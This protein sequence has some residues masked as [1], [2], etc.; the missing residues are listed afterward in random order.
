MGLDPN[1]RPILMEAVALTLPLRQDCSRARPQLL[2]DKLQC[3]PHT[4]AGSDSTGFAKIDWIAKVR[5]EV[6]TNI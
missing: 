1:A 4:Q 5:S 6:F 2:H 3:T